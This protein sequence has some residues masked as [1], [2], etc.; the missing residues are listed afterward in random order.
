MI[1]TLPLQPRLQ[2]DGVVVLRIFRRVEQRDASL[3][4]MP[5]QLAHRLLRSLFLQLRGIGAAERGP[6]LR[7]AV[8]ALAQGVAGRDLLQPQV[9]LRLVLGDAARPQAIDQDARAIT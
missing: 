9:D 8:E 6:V 5:A 3:A 7:M 1:T 4:R 2:R